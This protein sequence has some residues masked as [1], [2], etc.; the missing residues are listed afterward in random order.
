MADDFSSNMTGLESPGKNGAAIAPSDSVDLPNVTR[1]IYV[2][3]TGNLRV[4]L[5]SGDIIT[6]SNVQAGAIYPLRIARVFVTGTTATG[7]VGLR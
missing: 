4:A 2:G 5:V 1:A 3:V 7:L 6:L